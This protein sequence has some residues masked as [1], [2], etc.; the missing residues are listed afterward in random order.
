CFG[1]GFYETVSQ[2][3]PPR[4]PWGAWSPLPRP[5]S[6]RDGVLFGCVSFPH[7]TNLSLQ[8]LNK[9]RPVP[10]S[11]WDTCFLCCFACVPWIS[12]NWPGEQKTHA[13]HTTHAT[14]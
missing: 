4:L 14:N 1:G 12:P 9:A 7:T 5:C 13:K 11:E 8:V 3:T 10:S 6:E 2:G